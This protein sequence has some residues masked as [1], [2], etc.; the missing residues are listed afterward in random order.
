MLA[1]VASLMF[2]LQHVGKQDSSPITGG[3]TRSSRECSVVGTQINDR[4]R[5]KRS[6]RQ[7]PENS[8]ASEHLKHVS[9]SDIGE[10]GLVAV[11]KVGWGGVSSECR[12]SGDVD[13]RAEKGGKNMGQI[14]SV[15]WWTRCGEQGRGSQDTAWTL[16]GVWRVSCSLLCGRVLGK[17]RQRNLQKDQGNHALTHNRDSPL[18]GPLML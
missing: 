2:K 11:W 15:F 17:C 9:R 8:I 10:T 4:E 18:G 7:S 12:S 14:S 6:C 16:C 13:H 5:R 3:I 1:S